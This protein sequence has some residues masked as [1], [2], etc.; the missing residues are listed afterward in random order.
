MEKIKD[1]QV[2]IDQGKLNLL[3]LYLYRPQNFSVW[4]KCR[5]QNIKFRP[6]YGNHYIIQDVLNNYG[7]DTSLK[8]KVICSVILLMILSKMNCY[9]KKGKV[10]PLQARCDPEDGYRYSSNLL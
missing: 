1:L 3:V 9:I 7:E 10:I 8:E 4:T 2:N 5:V 6:V